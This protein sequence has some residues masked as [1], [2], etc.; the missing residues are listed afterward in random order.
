[1]QL[2]INTIQSTTNIPECMTMHELQEAMSQD[3]YLQH[4]HGVQLYTGWPVNQKTSYHKTSEH[5]GHSE[6]TWQLSMG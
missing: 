6:M 1:M 4:S 5:T 2:S 3:Q